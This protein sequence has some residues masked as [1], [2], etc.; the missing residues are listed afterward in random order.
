M[1]GLVN[2][3]QQSGK[4]IN[5]V[6]PRGDADVARH[7]FGKG[8]LA[9]VQPAPIEWESHGLEHI[10]RQLALA[11][12][13]EF[14]GQGRGGA[15]GLNFNGLIDESRELARQRL[16]DG[17]DIRGRDARRECIDQGIVG[18]KPRA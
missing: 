1:A 8:V 6:E 3:A 17:V 11:G 9:L 13:R 2:R 12:H 16:E 14:A 7:A 4:R 10:E 15:I 18:R 5:G